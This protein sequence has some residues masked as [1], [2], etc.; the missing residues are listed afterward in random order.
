MR[1]GWLP[2]HALGNGACE[3]RRAGPARGSGGGPHGED[4]RSRP[5]PAGLPLRP[6]PRGGAAPGAGTAAAVP[7]RGVAGVPG[8]GLAPGLRIPRGLGRPAV[9]VAVARTGESGFGGAALRQV[10]GGGG[11]EL[12]HGS[13]R[14]HSGRGVDCQ[15]DVGQAR[16]HRG[17]SL[18]C[19]HCPDAAA[20]AGHPVGLHPAV[21]RPHRLLL[22]HRPPRAWSSTSRGWTRPFA[23]SGTSSP[24]PAGPSSRPFSSTCRARSSPIPSFRRAAPGR[25]SVQWPPPSCSVRWPSPL[26]RWPRRWWAAWEICSATVLRRRWGW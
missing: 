9:H 3:R 7:A 6:G 15:L 13:Q 19:S 23:G 18:R 20:G 10:P 8:P 5:R 24:S 21:P 26:P 11:G 2:Q 4:A 17:L 16:R 25:C 1:P 12:R 14:V 22:R